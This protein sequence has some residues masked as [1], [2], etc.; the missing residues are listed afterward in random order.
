MQFIYFI[1]AKIIEFLGFVLYPGMSFDECTPNKIF[2]NRESGLPFPVFSERMYEKWKMFKIS[3]G[4][5]VHIVYFLPGY[6]I[7][8]YFKLLYPQLQLPKK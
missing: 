1:L 5:F 8:M 6:L 2:K 7:N 3:A 4:V